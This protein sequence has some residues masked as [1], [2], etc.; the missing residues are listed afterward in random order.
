MALKSRRKRGSIK[1][2]RHLALIKAIELAAQEVGQ[3]ILSPTQQV[4]KAKSKTKS[5]KSDYEQLKDE[6]EKLLG[7]VSSLLLENFELKQKAHL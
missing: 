2:S 6:Y 7:I 3:N 5:V 1:K 4:E